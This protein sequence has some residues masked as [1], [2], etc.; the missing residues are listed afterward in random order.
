[1]EAIDIL[2]AD[3]S[4]IDA[5]ERSDGLIEVIC[6]DITADDLLYTEKLMFYSNEMDNGRL[7]VVQM[8]DNGDLKPEMYKFNKLIHTWLHTAKTRRK[9]SK[10]KND[11]YD[12]ESI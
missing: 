5:Q 7:K 3:D 1:M 10:K 2:R 8:S 4:V 12:Q 11:E 9:Y 6:R